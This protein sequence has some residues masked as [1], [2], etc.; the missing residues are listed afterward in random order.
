[1]AGVFGDVG[2]DVAKWY[3]DKEFEPLLDRRR[4]PAEL[5]RPFPPVR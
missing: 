5:R 3:G 4:I 2:A 1:V